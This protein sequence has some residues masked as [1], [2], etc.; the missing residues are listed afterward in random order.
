MKKLCS[1]QRTRKGVLEGLERIKGSNKWCN[2]IIIS[3][4]RRHTSTPHFTLVSNQSPYI[5]WSVKKLGPARYISGALLNVLKWENYLS[6][7]FGFKNFKKQK[8]QNRWAHLSVA[9]A[10]TLCV[11]IRKLGHPRSRCDPRLLN[12]AAAPGE[13]KSRLSTGLRVCTQ[14][15]HMNIHY[16]PHTHKS[17]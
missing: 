6:L 16:L 17:C 2:Y 13:W 10:L 14:F 12:K 5:Y 7:T 15:S 11:C 8:K 3:K 9:S 4:R 1:W